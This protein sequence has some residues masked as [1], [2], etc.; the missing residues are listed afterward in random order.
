MSAW[1]KWKA[2]IIATLGAAGVWL[3]AI[4]AHQPTVDPPP[5]PIVACGADEWMTTAPYTDTVCGV[6]MIVPPE[7]RCDLASIGPVL[8]KPLGITRDHPTIRRGALLH[9]WLYRTHWTTRLQAD[10]ILY[11]CCLADGMEPAK[12]RAVYEAVLDWGWRAWER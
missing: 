4:M 12:A 8:S 5:L 2:A 6:T 11:Q 9:D 7:F 10:K 1:K 3:A